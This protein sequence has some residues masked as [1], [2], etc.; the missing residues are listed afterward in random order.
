M[1]Y[2]AAA[3]L[4]L[5]ALWF[6]RRSAVKRTKVTH[7]WLMLGSG[8]AWSMRSVTRDGFMLHDGPSV[9]PISNCVLAS[10]DESFGQV[11]VL[12]AASVNLVDYEQFSRIK[13]TAVKGAI[14]KP[15]G[16]L[17]HLLSMVG[18]VLVISAAIY[19]YTQSSAINSI[20]VAQQSQINDITEILSK[21]L[22]VAK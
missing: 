16:D 12:A 1:L 4:L 2:A 11:Y 7:C 3:G 19:S 9:Y 13:I 14:F 10:V 15:A 18:A 22:V 17:M 5:L 21:P 6:H 20:L 8:T